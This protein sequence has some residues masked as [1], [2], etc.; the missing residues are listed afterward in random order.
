MTELDAI[1]TIIFDMDGTL[2]DS[3][4]DFA[5]IRAE[6]QVPDETPI[7]EY[8][9]SAT[10]RNKQRAEEVLL[11]HEDRAAK[12]CKLFPDAEKVLCELRQ[13]G[14]NIAI[15][16]RNSRNS[17]QLVIERFGLEVDCVIS[18]DDADPKP[19]PQ[20]IHHIAHTLDTP[21]SNILVVG[22]YLFDLESALAA[23]ARSALIRT[24][25]TAPYLHRADLTLSTLSELLDYLA[26]SI[27]TKQ[28]T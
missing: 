25:R 27:P 16:T 26:P 20:P 17:A 23:G 21:V 5:R 1:E 15:L 9:D 18:R 13:R 11:K 6:A 2:V 14:H 10:G 4:L 12:S 28:K 19:S 24:D 3:D 8:I 7:L 22:D